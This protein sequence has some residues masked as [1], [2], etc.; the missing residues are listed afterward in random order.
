MVDG[1]SNLID[2]AEKTGLGQEHA[3]QIL[4]R[5]LAEGLVK[6]I[7]A[8]LERNEVEASG[9]VS[10]SVTELDPEEGVRAWAEAQRGAR[11][12][13]DHGFYA[14]AVR[15]LAGGAPPR[16]LSVEDDPLMARLLMVLLQREGFLVRHAAD[17]AA[18]YRMLAEET[19]DLVILDVMLPDTTGFKLLEW[20]RK[21][22]QFTDL[23]AI[24]LTAQVGEEDVMHG[25]RAGADGYIFKPFTPEPLL[26]CI[27][28]VLK[29]QRRE[30]A[31]PT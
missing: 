3:E 14:H 22:P 2:L 30:F 23:P 20:I 13:H 4:S 26:Q 6:E 5:L 1:R 10:I 18:A 16:I 15:P 19:P 8:S 24:M 21:Q 27:Y 9:Q 12:L 28:S 11:G 17:G 25:L 31:G 7:A 29:L